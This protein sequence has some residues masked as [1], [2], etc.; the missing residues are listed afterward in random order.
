MRGLTKLCYS[1]RVCKKIVDFV[2]IYM[3]LYTPEKFAFRGCHFLEKRRNSYG[4]VITEL[5]K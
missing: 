2:V 4:Q 1:V 3:E 5:Q